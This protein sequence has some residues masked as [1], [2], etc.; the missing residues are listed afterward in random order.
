MSAPPERLRFTPRSLVMAVA[1]LGLTL[2]L[3]RVFVASGRVIGWILAAS[4]LA[5][6]LHPLVVVLSRRI[7]R[8]AA[9]AVVALATVFV[10]AL[11]AYG[12]VDEV[13]DEAR[14]VQREAPQAA[15]RLE[16]DDRFGDVAT[17]LDLARRTQ[18]FVD[19]VPE[20]LRGG[21]A[22]E[23]L[24]SA[25]NRGVAFLAT[26]VLTLFFLLHGPRL[27][28]AAAEQIHD[29]D[30]RARAERVAAGAYRRAWRYI[31]GTLLMAAAAG[32]VS[33]LLARVA[34]VP[35]AAVLALWT[36]LWD[37]VPLIGAVLGALP[38]VLLAAVDST[39]TALA[40]S[41]VLV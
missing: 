21:T 10:V 41:T 4:T 3:M 15:R 8:G 22:E 39:S 37:V 6:L 30:R 16:R 33:L 26:G 11:V 13:V 32:L 5:G 38:I 14:V 24:R 18:E 2:A 9:I 23:A 29:P 1:L 19:D 12:V 17:D 34:D 25:A 36:A 27:A 20:L 28:A 31:A 40:V 35:G 7:P